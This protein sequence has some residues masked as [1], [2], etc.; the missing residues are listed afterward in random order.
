MEFQYQLLNTVRAIVLKL[1]MT[2]K[3]HLGSDVV[4]SAINVRK[5]PL[6]N[7]RTIVPVYTESYPTINFVV[8]SHSPENLQ[9]ETA[10]F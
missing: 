7:I 6:C 5:F 8:F 1:C 2:V 4:K 9:S 3:I 10:R